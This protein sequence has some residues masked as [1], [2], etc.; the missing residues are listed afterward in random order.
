MREF[1][2]FIELKLWVEGKVVGSKLRLTSGR[3]VLLSH[4]KLGNDQPSLTCAIRCTN[5]VIKR[6]SKVELDTSSECVMK[7]VQSGN[8]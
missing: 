2:L 7:R 4:S 1:A 5:E 8:F 6:L 3:L